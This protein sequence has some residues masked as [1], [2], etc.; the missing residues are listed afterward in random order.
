MERQ[1]LVLDRLVHL[2]SEGEVASVLEK[3]ASWFS[4]GEIDVSLVR[5][6]VTEVRFK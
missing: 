1:K 4:D 3:V 5:Y 2:F 6:F